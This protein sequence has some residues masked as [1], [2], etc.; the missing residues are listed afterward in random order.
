[1]WTE[2][3]K[4]M[5]MVCYAIATMG[6]LLFKVHGLVLRSLLRSLHY[7][8]MLVGSALRFVAYGG[9]NLTK[10]EVILLTSKKRES[11]RAN[12]SNATHGGRTSL[13]NPQAVRDAT[14]PGAK[15]IGFKR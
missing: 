8:R 6:D 4:G 12:S 15:K 9:Y 3:V 13:W 11:S 14:M 10:E 7:L 2:V 5:I 1:M